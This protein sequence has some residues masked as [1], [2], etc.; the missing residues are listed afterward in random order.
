MLGYPK[1]LRGARM[2]KVTNRRSLLNA[3]GL[4]ALSTSLKL[5]AQVVTESEPKVIAQGTLDVVTFSPGPP[6]SSYPKGT[7]LVL[8]GTYINPTSGITAQPSILMPFL[9]L[10][11]MSRAKRNRTLKRAVID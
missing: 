5:K 2:S 4:T 7:S 1:E 3:I 11:D 8:M 10:I 6:S 9:P